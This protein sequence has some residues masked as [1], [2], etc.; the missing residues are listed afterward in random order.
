LSQLRLVAIR[1]RGERAPRAPVP[2]M[3]DCEWPSVTIQLPIYNE[4]YVV[5]RLLRSVAAIDYPTDRLTVQVLDDSSDRTALIVAELVSELRA[6]G[7]RIERIRRPRRVGFKAGAL[8]YGLRTAPGELLAVFDADFVPAPDVLRVMVPHFQAPDVGAVQARWAF[9]NEAESRLTRIEAFMLDLHFGLEQPAR[10]F[11]GLF[12]N[13]NG[14]GGIW[15]RAAIEDAG[16][17][18]ARTL[19]EDIDLSYR[20]QRRG[21]RLVYLSG[22]DCPGELPAQ[23]SGLRSQQ[24]RWMKGGAQ[25][26]R[27]HLLGIMRGSQPRHVRRHACLHLLAGSTYLVIMSVILL[28]V[29]LTV[30]V[31]T[32]ITFDYADYGLAFAISTL[33]LVGVFHA[34]RRPEGMKGNLRFALDMAAFMLFTIGL[35]V[36]NGLAVLSGWGSLGGEFVRTPKAGPGAWSSTSYARQTVDPRVV[37]E[38]VVMLYLGTGLALGRRRRQYTLMPVQALALTGLGWVVGLSLWH[39]LRV[40]RRAS[41]HTARE[42]RV[43]RTTTTSPRMAYL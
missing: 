38:I 9:L 15:R 16:G 25:N 42:L 35:A 37:P 17:W 18:S 2:S 26:A 36:H 14:T 4:Q 34:A 23:M 5:E 24:Y 20:A 1:H 30:L 43:E 32:S 10:Q 39:P 19:T 22:Y 7:L 40:Q 3:A 41:A 29:P 13:F 12:L 27:L 28:S 6:A 8:A 31:G 33:A 21:W 11:G